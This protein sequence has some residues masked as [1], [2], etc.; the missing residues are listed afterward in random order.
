MKIQLIFLL[1]LSACSQFDQITVCDEQAGLKA[2]EADNLSS[3]YEALKGCAN[4][5]ASGKALHDLHV[6]IFP[7]GLG[8]YKSL[9]QRIIDSQ[10]LNCRA[11]LAG[12]EVSVS[13]LAH[14]YLYGSSYMSVSPIP[15]VSLCLSTIP[16]SSSSEYVD[17]KYVQA[18]LSLNPDID[19]TYECY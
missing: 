16:A 3:A 7:E 4:T 13:S 11:A 2:I 6:L 15:E 5:D 14:T 10:G 1:A 9:D 17:P 12:Y 19:P 18:C 8:S